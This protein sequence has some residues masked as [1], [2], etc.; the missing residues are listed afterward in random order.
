MVSA[1]SILLFFVGIG[2]RNRYQR[3]SEVGVF[4]LFETVDQNPLQVNMTMFGVLMIQYLINNMSVVPKGILKNLVF[5]C[6]VE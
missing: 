6:L 1:F 5:C 4:N 2:C 3:G